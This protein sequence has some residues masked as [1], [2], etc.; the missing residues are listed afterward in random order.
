[1]LNPELEK[2]T[3][4]FA[5]W[6]AQTRPL[7]ELRKAQK[8][9]A[10]DAEAQHL[11]TE[12]EAKQQELLKRQQDGQAIS[13]ADITPLRQL[14][15][16]IRN[17]P[18]VQTYAEMHQQAQLYLTNLSEEISQELQLDWETLSRIGGEEQLEI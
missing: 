17:H 7:A 18:A 14:Q 2:A 6:L 8:Q 3:R 10:A 4:N 12:W 11:L 1:M 5:A 13:L 16:Q 9:L 15:A